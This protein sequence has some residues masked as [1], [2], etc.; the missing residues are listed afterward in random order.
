MANQSMERMFRGGPWY[1]VDF[2]RRE[3]LRYTG[4]KK[5]CPGKRYATWSPAIR[6]ARAYKNP[7][8]AA[9]MANLINAERGRDDCQALGKDAAMCV[10]DINRRDGLPVRETG[11]DGEAVIR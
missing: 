9:K 10:D 5:G 2:A 7:S 3:F 4:R 11:G 8:K 6:W 1:V